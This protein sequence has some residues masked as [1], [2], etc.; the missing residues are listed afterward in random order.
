MAQMQGARPDPRDRL[1]VALDVC[2]VEQAEAVIERLGEAVAF[3]KIGYQLGFAGGLALG[4]ALL[5]AGIRVFFDFKLH[6][7]GH[8]VARGVETFARMGATFLT[9]HGYP[10]TMRAA[11]TARGGAPLRLLAVT[12]LTSYDD[13]DVA[14][15]GYRFGVKPLTRLRAEQ[16]HALGVDGLV[17]AGEEVGTVRAAIGS[18]MLVVTP[19]IRPSGTAALDQKRVLTPAQAMAAGADYLVVGRPILQAPDPRAAAR[20]IVAELAAALE[21]QQEA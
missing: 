4:E 18:Q 20:A 5:R 10:Q 2:S 15:A 16:A 13:A 14:A 11:V 1:I 21:T 6:D 3:Y 12:V 8:T 17:C 7:I 9:V 19:G